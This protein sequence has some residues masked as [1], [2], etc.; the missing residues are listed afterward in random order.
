M[1]TRFLTQANVGICALLLSACGGGSTAT[2]AGESSTPTTL[3]PQ[4]AP[5]VYLG[6]LNGKDWVSI[7][8]RTTGGSGSVTNF[9]GLHYTATDPDIFSGSGLITGTTSALLTRIFYYPNISGAVRVGTGVIDNLGEKNVRTSLNFPATGLE[10]SKEVTVVASQSS[11]YPNNLPASLND[12]QGSWKGRWSYGLGFVDN[13][14]L[15][16]SGQGEITTSS[17]FQQDCMLTQGQLTANFDGSNLF[18]FSM[19]LPNATQCS[20]K[21]QSLNG[22]GFVLNSPVVGKTQRLFIVGVT[23][24]GKGISFKA[25][26]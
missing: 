22:A 14:S 18:T 20:L 10:Q 12:I 13:F 6:S 15:N 3:T 25:D 19:T 4:T 8:L 9:Y 5:G 7:L 26:R 24:D 11:T 23:P 21:S 2:T 1:F 16:I 17:A